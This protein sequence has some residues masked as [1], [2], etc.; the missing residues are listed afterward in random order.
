MRNLIPFA[1]LFLFSLSSYAQSV[2][3]KV[4]ELFT[5][6][7]Q[8]S[9]YQV[10][11]TYSHV[12]DRM[13]FSNVQEGFLVVQY[14]KYILK[15]GETEIWLNDGNTEYVGTQEED[16]SQIL[17]FCPGKNGEAIIDFLKLMTF[18]G[19]G[20]SSNLKGNI[21]KLVPQSEMPY[22]EAF[23]KFTDSNIQSIQFLD[24]LGSAYTYTL[25]DFN[26]DTSGTRFV[27]NENEYREKIDER[28]GCK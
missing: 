13:G 14:D 24:N 27:I 5:K 4:N 6:Y 3:S 9:N 21:I 12:N 26:T 17:Y 7:S 11:I 25:S 19:S 2:Q 28:V 16:H 15:Y 23:I 1:F 18:Y 20:H 22:V 10:K 8:I